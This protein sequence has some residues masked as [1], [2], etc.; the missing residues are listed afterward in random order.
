M[1]KEIKN[2]LPTIFDIV[3]HRRLVNRLKKKTKSVLSMYDVAFNTDRS[4]V[5]DLAE[6][7]NISESL[8][9]SFLIVFFEE[10]K[11]EMMNGGIINIPGLGK[12]YVNGPHKGSSG[13]AI[14]PPENC[15]L[16]PKFKPFKSIK[17]RLIK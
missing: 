12:F 15:R 8:A 17:K 11:K 6:K 14:I 9:L 5:D 3:E 13:K 10:I 16:T 1:I 2:P 4:L 7:C